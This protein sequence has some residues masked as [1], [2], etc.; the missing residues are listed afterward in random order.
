MP[1]AWRFVHQLFQIFGRTVGMF[2]REKVLGRI[3]PAVVAREFL[4]GQELDAVDAQIDEVVEFFDDVLK[5]PSLPDVGLS[6]GEVTDMQFINDEFIVGREGLVIVFPLVFVDADFSV[7][8]SHQAIAGGIVD[9]CGFG[10]GD[11][12]PLI[13]FIEP[14]FGLDAEAVGVFAI[15]EFDGDAPETFDVFGHVE[16]GPA[17]EGADEFCAFDGGGKE[18]DFDGGGR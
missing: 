16:V 11:G 1:P 13:F 9:P 12:D 2:G 14:R 10:I 7:A 5:F 6:A 8:D 18:G 4:D 15:G 3:T 17:G